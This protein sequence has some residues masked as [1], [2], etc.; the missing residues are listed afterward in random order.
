MP[1][2]VDG[3]LKKDIV[4]D[5]PKWKRK[6]KVKFL[7]ERVMADTTQPFAKKDLIFKQSKAR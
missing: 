4:K 6:E 2:V 7:A 3:I 1:E 5:G